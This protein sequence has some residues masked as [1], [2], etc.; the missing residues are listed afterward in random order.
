MTMLN[1]RPPVHD[2]PSTAE[3]SAPNGHRLDIHI[4]ITTDATDLTRL[5]PLITQLRNLLYRH[6]CFPDEGPRPDSIRYTFGFTR[7]TREALWRQLYEPAT[8]PAMRRT[9]SDT[10]PQAPGRGVRA[11]ARR[12]SRRLEPHALLDRSRRKPLFHRRPHR[13]TRATT[14]RSAAGLLRP[15][16]PPGGTVT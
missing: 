7:T 3:P 16:G 12:R 4:G 13:R 5:A 15:F 6:R 10:R 8:V 9:C 1:P 2:C 14:P 11:R